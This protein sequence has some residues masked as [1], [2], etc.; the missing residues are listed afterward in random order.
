MKI[1]VI[2][3]V[4]LLIFG[5]MSVFG[6]SRML[7]K[8]QEWVIM[9]PFEAQILMNGEPLTG[10]KVKLNYSWTSSPDDEIDGTTLNF[11]TDADGTVA[12]PSVTEKI[13]VSEIYPTASNYEL[14]V[15]AG[16]KSTPIAYITKRDPQ[17]YGELG[18]KPETVVCEITKPLSAIID[19]K[20]TSRH[21]SRCSW[22]GSDQ[23]NWV[24]MK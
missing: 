15:E 7:G 9:S 19:K 10:A 21:I 16:G 23:Y 20:I 11:Q 13:Y 3:A 22:E 4:I 5:A 17:L 6:M 14:S 1:I 12:M 24:E 2:L 8:K 18:Y